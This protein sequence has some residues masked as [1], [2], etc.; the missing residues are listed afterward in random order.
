MAPGQHAA[1]TV[2][3]G[4]EYSLW[5]L[6]IRERKASPFGDVRSTF[7]TDSVFSPDGR[8]VAYQIGEPYAGEATTFVEPFPRTGTKY[9]VGRG[10]C[11]QWSRD[12]KEL[13]YVPGPSLFA[14]V[15]IRT[16]PSVTFANAVVVP[17]SAVTLDATNANSGTV[18]VVD[19]QSIAHE[20]HV[21]IGAHTRD[22]TQIV[23]GLRG[24]ENVVIEGNYGLPDGTK[25][26]IAKDVAANA[27]VRRL[28]AALDCASLLARRQ[29]AGILGRRQAAALLD[30]RFARR[31]AAIGD[32]REIARE[33]RLQ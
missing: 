4:L 13:F 9:Q 30:Q 11:P 31:V 10:G 21:T 14:A 33:E 20:V 15:G 18:M 25:V 29:A 8:W 16:Q 12:G 3:R 23:S 24:G 1:D 19:A 17:T 5:T 27:G 6:S 2:R 22:K 32:V 28:A 7:P 26:A